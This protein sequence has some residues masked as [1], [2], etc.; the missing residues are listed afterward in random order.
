MAGLM[1]VTAFLS[2]WI[3]N[4]AAALIMVTVSSVIIDELENEQKKYDETKRVI[5]EASPAETGIKIVLQWSRSD[6]MDAF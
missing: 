6:G 3:N 4:V 1:G 2:M 5:K